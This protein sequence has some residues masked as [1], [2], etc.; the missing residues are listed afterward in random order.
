MALF[1]GAVRSELLRQEVPVSVLLPDRPPPNTPVLYLLHGLSQD[2]TSWVRFSRLES[3]VQSRRLA[4]VMPTAWRTFYA[5]TTYGLRYFSFLSDELPA[6]MTSMFP[7]A[8]GRAHTFVCGNSMGGY[9][10]LKLGLRFPE[11]FAAVASLSGALIQARM[12]TDRVAEKGQDDPVRHE[13]HTVFGQTV[14]PEDDVVCLAQ[15]AA[16]LETKPRIRLL[17]GGLD[18]FAPYHRLYQRHLQT[19]GL[20]VSYE[21]RENAG[22][23][24]PYWDDAIQDVLHWL[25]PM[26]QG[27]ADSAIP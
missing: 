12:L 7:L 20:D 8:T 10:A 18:H 16:A 14:A 3:Y 11:R 25:D 24:W 1:T 5:D 17:C 23:D 4:V 27:N 2:H 26:L 6:L 9:G 21:E 19:L 13:L 22:H 15:S